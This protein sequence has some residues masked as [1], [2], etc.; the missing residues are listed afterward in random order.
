M[1][2]F[3]YQYNRLDLSKYQYVSGTIEDHKLCVGVMVVERQG[4]SRCM[5]VAQV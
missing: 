3:H 2:G 1:K 5:H 4:M